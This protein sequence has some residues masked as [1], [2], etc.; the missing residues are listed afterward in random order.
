MQNKTMIKE[1]KKRKVKNYEFTQMGIL[2]YSSRISEIREQGITVNK[3]RL[4]D[5]QG[6]ATGVFVYWIPRI[7]SK[8]G[9]EYE[10]L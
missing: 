9:M 1:M 2:R 7:T 10:E 4:Y 8:D 5:K 6:K 3:E